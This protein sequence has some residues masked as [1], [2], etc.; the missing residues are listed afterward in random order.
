V[1]AACLL[2][3]HGV[4]PGE[5]VAIVG[6]GAWSDALGLALRLRGAQVLGPFEPSEVLRARGRPTVRG[7]DVVRG[8]GES[9]EKE[10][11]A[12]DCVAIAP[13]P[14]PVYELAEQAG[15]SVVFSGEAFVVAAERSDGATSAPRLFAVGECTGVEGLRQILAQAREAGDR[16][17]AS[18]SGVAADV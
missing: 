7:L 14:S 17:A 16:A 1:R 13:P 3:R 9:A 5:R 4:L 18:L 2:L 15:A 12:C 10:T 8:A 11:L 6:K